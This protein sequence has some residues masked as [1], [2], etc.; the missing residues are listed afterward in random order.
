MTRL[1]DKAKLLMV[2]MTIV[3]TLSIAFWFVPKPEYRGV[4]KVDAKLT[5]MLEAKQLIGDISGEN[6]QY[7][8]HTQEKAFIE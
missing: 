1:L 2:L 5:T 6:L 7:Q 3:G 4:V 8:W